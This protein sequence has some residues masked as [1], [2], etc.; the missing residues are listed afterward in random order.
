MKTLEKQAPIWGEGKRLVKKTGGGWG[1]RGGI[2]GGGCRVAGL[3]DKH[4]R[5]PWGLGGVRG[6]T[7][8]GREGK[9]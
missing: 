9:K 1:R 6:R 2:G 7:I 5:A 3:R 8:S 4:L